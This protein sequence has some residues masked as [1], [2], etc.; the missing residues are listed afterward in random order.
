MSHLQLGN[1]GRK[2]EEKVSDRFGLVSSHRENEAGSGEA[3]LA[4][5][6]A[7]GAGSRPMK[8]QAP[9]TD[10]SEWALPGWGRRG[11]AI[12]RSEKVRT[13]LRAWPL[14]ITVWKWMMNLA[15]SHCTPECLTA[16]GFF[17]VPSR[18]HRRDSPGLHAETFGSFSATYYHRISRVFADIAFENFF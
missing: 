17:Q 5:A 16:G 3:N 11:K 13:F 7:A 9:K 2:R 8:S 4:L 15:I 6:N 10:V 1:G 12:C 18:E 14:S